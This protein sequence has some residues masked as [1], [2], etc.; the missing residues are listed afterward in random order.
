M[1]AIKVLIVEPGKEPREAEI[2]NTLSAQQA[3]VGGMIEAIYPWDDP[4]GLICNE[5]GKLMGL[6]LN[7]SLEGYDIIAGTSSSAGSV[8]ITSTLFPRNSWKSI[9]KS[10]CLQKCFSESAVIFSRSDSV[11]QGANQMKRKTHEAALLIRIRNQCDLTQAKFACLLHVSRGTY[12]NY[13]AGRPA[14]PNDRMDDAI[15]ILRK[16]K[17]DALINERVEQKWTRK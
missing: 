12:A 4:V 17:P 6:P 11:R 3:V 5:E 8:R 16:V 10:S 13:E 15:S 9:R 7:R 1:Q 2:E 14:V